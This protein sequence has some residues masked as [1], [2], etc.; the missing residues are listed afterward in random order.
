MNRRSYNRIASAWDQARCSLSGRERDCLNT[1]TDGLPAGTAI[2]DLGCGTGRPMA[3]ELLQRGHHVT[4]VDQAGDL[5]ALARSRFPQA[6]WIESRIETFTTSQR[7]GGIL[8]WDAL[9]HI[10]RVLQPA[11]LARMARMLQDGGRLMLTIGGSD[12]PAFTDTMFGETFF[13]DSLPP[14]EVTTLLGDLNF[15]LPVAEFLNLP[16][17]GRDKGRFAIVAQRKAPAA[18]A[19]ELQVKSPHQP[20]GQGSVQRP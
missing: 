5:L 9:F 15:A 8:C 20:I 3:A 4:G 6:T 2:L 12:H 13:Y 18:P 14:G 17:D 7:F 19:D 16:T 11:L 10:S 1:F